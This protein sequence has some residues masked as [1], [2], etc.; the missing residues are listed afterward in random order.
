[1]KFEK[2]TISYEYKRFGAMLYLLQK[3][4]RKYLND[5]LAKHNINLLQAMILLILNDIENATQKDLADIMYLTKSGITKAINNLEKQGYIKK[6][7]SPKDGRSFVLKL[8][9]KGQKIL[10]TINQ[11]NDEWEEKIGV[12]ELS[13][14]FKDTI[15]ELTYKSIQLNYESE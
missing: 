13:D 9:E 2:V 14:E 7:K 1:M 12:S 3:N 5:E 8:S 11:I 15:E 6:E 4:N 10:P